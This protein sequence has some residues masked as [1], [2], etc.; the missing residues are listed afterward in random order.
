MLKHLVLQ[1]GGENGQEQQDTKCVT[2]YVFFK[3]KG[4][5][6]KNVIFRALESLTLCQNSYEQILISLLDKRTD[7]RTRENPMT[8]CGTKKGQNSLNKNFPGTFAT[9]FNK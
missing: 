6:G 1:I 4:Q 7:K 5:N 2:T 8:E 3:K 9:L